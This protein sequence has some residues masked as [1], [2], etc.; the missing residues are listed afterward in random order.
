MIDA[1]KPLGI[2]L[3]GR[4]KY[5]GDWEGYYV[6]KPG[7]AVFSITPD[8]AAI[9]DA[10]DAALITELQRRG[11]QVS[12][13]EKLIVATSFGKLGAAAG[14]EL[15]RFPE[16]ILFLERDD[17]K[18]QRIAVVGDLSR[19]DP[20]EDSIR[21]GVYGNPSCVELSDAIHIPRSSIFSPHAL[22]EEWKD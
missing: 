4:I 7:E 20:A 17:G 8:E 3:E 18:K 2:Q 1:L 14:E 9:L 16:I 6:V 22:W 11:F 12:Q 21:V 19:D 15:D 13:A 5:Y 10:S